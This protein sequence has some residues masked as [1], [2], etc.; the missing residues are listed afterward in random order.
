[1]PISLQD[2]GNP[3]SYRNIWIRELNTQRLFNGK[4]LNGWYSYLDTLGK[5]NDPDKNFKVENGMIYIRG[6][7]FGYLSTEKSYSNY[8]LKA[9]FKWGEKRYPP[10]EN[11]KRDSGILYN[12][13]ENTPDKVWPTSLECQVQEG[14][15]GDYWCVG[16]ASIDSPNNSEFKWNQKHIFRTQNFENPKG[17]WNTIEIITNGNQ[18]EHYINGQLVNWG[19]NASVSEGKILLQSEG[20]EVYY[21]NIEI[22]DF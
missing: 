14:D 16:G 13:S 15:C 1:M 3:V 7:Q 19:K 17:D 4:D 12:F 6:K 11:D 21:R 22:S 8:Y 5:N 2:H 20:A 9:E 18:S 10:R